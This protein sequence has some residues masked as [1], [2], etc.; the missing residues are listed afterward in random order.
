METANKKTDTFTCSICND[1]FTGF[2]NNAQP[3]NEGR[4][5][6]VCDGCIVI[7]ARIK[8]VISI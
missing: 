1:M 7:P 3:I 5:C 6:D 2:G 8:N 4:C